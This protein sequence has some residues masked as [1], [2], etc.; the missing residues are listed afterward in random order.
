M[1]KIVSL[2]TMLMLFMASAIAQNK[3]VTGKVTESNG[4]PVSGATISA[5]GKP[6]GA[7]TTSGD[8][9]VTVPTATT[10][11]VVTSIGFN[12]RTVT[13]TGSALSITLT[14]AD[15]GN[16]A[17]VVVTGYTSIQR[18]KF[19]GAIANVSAAEIKKQ[20]LVHLTRPFRVRLRVYL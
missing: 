17:E 4:T 5:N 19:S 7:T 15:A 11:I 6:V 9:S 3:T 8:F 16:V 1:R 20:P 14:S 2:L 13:L 18:K 12:D 10:S